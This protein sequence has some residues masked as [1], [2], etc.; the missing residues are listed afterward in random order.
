MHV[1]SSD[2]SVGSVWPCVHKYEI[3]GISRSNMVGAGEEEFSYLALS[4]PDATSVLSPLFDGAA[5]DGK[6]LSMKDKIELL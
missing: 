1:C 2:T 4:L 5:H 6:N 3:P